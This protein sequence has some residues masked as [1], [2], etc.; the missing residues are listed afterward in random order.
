MSVKTTLIEINSCHYPARLMTKE[1]TSLFPRFWAIGNLDLLEKRLWGLFC[2]AQCPGD[3]I[4][5]TYDV[6]RVLRDTGLPVIGGF[7]S[8]MEKECLDL[9]LRGKQPVI[10]CPARNID[11]MRLPAIWKD[12]LADGRL[13]VLS[14]FEEKHR[15]LTAD[16]A[17]ERNRFVGML[18]YALF[19]MYA[20]PGSKTE[21]LC[22]TMIEQGKII[23][24][25]DRGGSD[26]LTAVGAVST[27]VDTL[28]YSLHDILGNY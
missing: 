2:S 19:V 14:P 6:I 16:L 21:Q 7:H 1:G 10:I 26:R 28:Q 11:G 27:A 8:P 3:V 25:T 17:A 20:A 18:A 4:V 15:R 12:P 22:L 23:L 9:L 5:Q 24:T 13:L